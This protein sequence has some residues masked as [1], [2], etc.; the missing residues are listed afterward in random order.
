MGLSDT[1]KIIYD[2]RQNTVPPKKN[3]IQVKIESKRSKT[4]FCAAAGA[5]SFVF[6][7]ITLTVAKHPALET[8][9]SS[10]R[11]F[12]SHLV[13]STP[14]V[15]LTNLVATHLKFSV[16]LPQAV[17]ELKLMLMV[18]PEGTIGEEVLPER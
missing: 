9:V 13:V 5:S 7:S 3:Q 1:E 17:I 16:L 2:L 10:G 12:V 4:S 18:K 11:L 15:L 6:A 14:K 8:V